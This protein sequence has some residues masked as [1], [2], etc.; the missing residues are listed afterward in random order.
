MN[1]Q[2]YYYFTLLLIALILIPACSTREVV[3]EEAEARAAEE[4]NEYEKSFDPAE[5]NDPFILEQEPSR[6]PDRESGRFPE[7]ELP[8]EQDFIQGFRIQLYSSADMEAAQEVYNFADSLFNELWIYVVYE[9]PFYKIRLGDFQTRPQANKILT[10]VMRKGF[11]DA[12]VVPDRVLKD[13]P[14]KI[15]DVQPPVDEESP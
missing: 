10:E 6:Q 13:P 14:I 4:L 7:L 3:R 11:R 9:V 1:M 15:I 2:Y 12:W 5:Y 8:E